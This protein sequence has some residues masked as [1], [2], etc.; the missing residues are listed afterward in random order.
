MAHYRYPFCS[1]NV[2]KGILL[3]YF[4]LFK[5][6]AADL[7]ILIGRYGLYIVFVIGK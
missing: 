1:V 4:S 2:K 6:C 7:W 3:D 5:L